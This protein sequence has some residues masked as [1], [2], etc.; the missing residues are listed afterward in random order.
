MES[1]GLSNK[2][3]VVADSKKLEN[4]SQHKLNFY[5]VYA[6]V[7]SETLKKPFFQKFLHWILKKEGI[8]KKEV[9]D[10]QIRVFPLQK[11]NGNSLAGR[12]NTSQGIIHIF[13]KKQCFVKKKIG[14]A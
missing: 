14:K 7:V 12:C 1:S 4:C 9:S 11:D 2:I 13:P 3:R 6:S 5:N 8:E 10:I